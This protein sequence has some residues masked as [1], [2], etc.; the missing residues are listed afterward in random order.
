MTLVILSIICMF[1]STLSS[2][3]VEPKNT[4]FQRYVPKLIATS[5]YYVIIQPKMM[6][7]FSDPCVDHCDFLPQHNTRVL[8][9]LTTQPHII[10]LFF[11]LFCLMFFSVEIIVRFI[12]GRQRWRMLKSFTTICDFLYLI[13]TWFMFAIDFYD[14]TFWHNVNRV[15]VFL[16]FQTLMALRVLRLFRFTR[17]YHGLKTLWL[18]VKASKR[19]LFLLFIFM[20]MATTF[21]ATFIFCTEFFEVSSYYNNIYIGMWW[22]LI[23]MT[24]VGYGDFYPNSALGYILA[25][26]CALTGII[27]M[28]MPVPL[29]ARNFHSFYGL[30]FYHSREHHIRHIKYDMDNDTEKDVPR[31]TPDKA[32]TEKFGPPE[33]MAKKEP[34]ENQTG[35]ELIVTSEKTGGDKFAETVGCA[36]QKRN[37]LLALFENNK[38]SP[39]DE[40]GVEVTQRK[41]RKSL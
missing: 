18:A 9:F 10:L 29:I 40:N 16:L 13:P 41:R 22:S 15:G 25:S 7:N 17:H 23:T 14:R 27:L 33:R 28:G 32:D 8:S 26:M 3:R 36:L 1:T 24:T 4:F 30:Q 35:V 19:E 21:Y 5:S 12:F 31:E 11:D 6:T 2:C 37:K 20:I 34:R 38:V 39:V